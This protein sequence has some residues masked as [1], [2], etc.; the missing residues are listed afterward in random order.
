MLAELLLLV[1]DE[2][3]DCANAMLDINANTRTAIGQP[4]I[5]LLMTAS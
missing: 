3:D 5:L 1:V 2:V 4:A